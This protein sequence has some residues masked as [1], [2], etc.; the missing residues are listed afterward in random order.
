MFAILFSESAQ[1]RSHRVNDGQVGED[2]GHWMA[3]LTCFNM[4]KTLPT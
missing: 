4:F 1:L 3:V 2:L